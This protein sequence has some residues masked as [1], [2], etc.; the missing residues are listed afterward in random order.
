M[1]L[2]PV[3]LGSSGPVRMLLLFVALAVFACT[4]GTDDDAISKDQETVHGLIR[5]VEAQSLLELK[6][7]DLTDESGKTWHFEANGRIFAL[8]TPS[9]LNE[10]MLQGQRV[11]VVFRRQ[12]DVLILENITD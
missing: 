11:T 9:H 10:H 4:G 1:A 2:S 3:K 8:F 5:A 7:L 6:S 12:G